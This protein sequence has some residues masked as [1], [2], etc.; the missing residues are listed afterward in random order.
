MRLNKK[1]LAALAMSAVMAASAVP[2]PVYAEELSAGDDVVADVLTDDVAEAP[3]TEAPEAGAAIAG[4][5]SSTAY[6]YDEATHAVT[7]LIV[8]YG[9]G[10]I[11]TYTKKDDIDKYVTVKDAK[12][13]TCKEFATA[14]IVVEIGD[15]SKTFNHVGKTYAEHVEGTETD[16]FLIEA[17]NCGTGKKAVW[18]K[19]ALC[20]VCGEKTGSVLERDERDPEHAKGT[21]SYEVDETAKADKNDKIYNTKLVDGKP[22][23]VDPSTKGGYAEKYTCT[24]CGDEVVEYKEIAAESYSNVKIVAAN[25]ATHKS[26]NIENITKT[27]GY[28]VSDFP[29][30]QEDAAEIF[31]LTNCEKDGTYW[32]EYSYEDGKKV[33]QSYTVDAHHWNTFDTIVLDKK[34]QN[35]VNVKADKDGNLYVE[36]ETCN[37][38]I[39]YTIVTH[40][41]SST[42]DNE[43][44]KVGT[45][46]VE[47]V[48]NNSQWDG[49]AHAHVVSEVK[50]EVAPSEKH[51]LHRTP[52]IDALLKT[53]KSTTIATLLQAWKEDG[54]NEDVV[55]EIPENICELGGTAK[56]NWVCKVCDKVVKT[57]EIKINPS[58]HGDGVVSIENE[59]PATCTA[60]G[61]KDEVTRCEYCNKEL[62]R[63]TI[64]IAKK[65][66]TNETTPGHNSTS[67]KD[68]YIVV[69]G[70]KVVDNDGAL[71]NVKKGTELSGS[72]I[73]INGKHR[74]FVGYKKNG[75]TQ[76]EFG[77]YPKVVTNCSVCGKN[78][79]DLKVNMDGTKVTLVD[80]QKQDSKG[81]NGYITLKV[82]YTR[83]SPDSDKKTIETTVKLPYFSSM[84]AYTGRTEPEVKDGLVQDKDG[85]YRYYVNGEFQKDYTGILDYAGNKYLIVS[86]ELA[87]DVNGLWYSE[88]DKVWYFLVEG[89]VR[90]DYT[91]TA[92]YDGEWFYV[93][94]GRLNEAVNGLVP[95][96]GGTFL[97]VEGRLRKDVSGLWQD[98]NNPE[99]WYFLALGQVQ[100]QYTGV[101]QYDGGFFVV[102]EGKFDKK[103]NGTIKYDGETFKVVNGQL[104]IK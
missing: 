51:Q 32:V 12:D 16:W 90:T 83:T 66:H 67:D 22:V 10:I 57:K 92:L 44:H 73:Q 78:E 80:I 26:V 25:D 93:S 56:I 48:E 75:A 8:S 82:E 11:E 29:L 61:S 79:A 14:T 1:R 77:V 76:A 21:V 60:T 30:S 58:A 18:G 88:A 64:T 41:I 13:A 103:Y 99:D 74:D 97:F 15:Y 39:P 38:T 3:V 55:L 81:Q 46:E 65:A 23:L 62:D 5:I 72:T 20:E 86:G 2:F 54:K 6:E 43:A 28:Q 71:L 17:G 42:C 53:G 7:K 49:K 101:A 47:L 34:Y 102:K 19:Y 91:G 50:T 96:N 69:V 37:Q 104:I 36:N 84:E 31:Q 95:Y 87:K 100:T 4:E 98:I 24:V 70:D 45:N 27:E 40:C 52:K 9:G 89:A 68:S 35:L 59:V 33:Y 63:K 85:V 94:N